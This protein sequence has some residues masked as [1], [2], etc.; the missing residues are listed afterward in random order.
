MARYRHKEQSFGAWFAW[1]AASLV[2]ALV[3]YGIYYQYV[4]HTVN[5]MGQDIIESSNKA[6]QKIIDQS[7]Q[8]QADQQRQR[9]EKAAKE[10]AIADAQLRAQQL[11]QEKLR[12][13]EQAWQAYFKPSTK[14]IADPITTECANAH[15]RAKGEFE[16]SYKEQN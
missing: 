14:C 15:I 5:K 3:A 12:R 10:A 1:S 8:I 16:A 7:R 9:D 2:F 13:K 4:M 11:V 6:S